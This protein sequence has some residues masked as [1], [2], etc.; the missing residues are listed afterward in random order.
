M[1]FAWSRVL[2]QRKRGMG[3]RTL[4]LLNRETTGATAVYQDSGT[5]QFRDYGAGGRGGP[6]LSMKRRSSREL[7]SPG[8]EDPRMVRGPNLTSISGPRSPEAGIPSVSYTA[9]TCSRRL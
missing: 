8:L 7:L 5:G 4:R 1:T 6:R 9:D 2:G 3:N